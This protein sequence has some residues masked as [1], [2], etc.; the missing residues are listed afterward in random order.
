[1]A[2]PEPQ[3]ELESGY[4]SALGSSTRFEVDDSSLTLIDDSGEVLVRFSVSEPFSITSTPWEVLAY[5]NGMGGFTSVLLDT[6][7]TGK[8]AEDG[9][10]SGLASCNNY[11]ASYEIE[12]GSITIG[13]I[14]L[15]Q[16]FCGEPEGIMEQEA[17]YL[18]A[19]QTTATFTIKLDQLNLSMQRA[20]AW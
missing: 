7:I 8:F 11:N 16:M 15:T 19:L 20:R 9:A 5:N 17:H 13:P 3:M 12:G 4:L 10:L 1:M 2:C 18:A 14:A 6:S